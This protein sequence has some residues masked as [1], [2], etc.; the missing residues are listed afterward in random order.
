M[1]YFK[2]DGAC[3]F[4]GPSG[5]D[6][7]ETVKHDLPRLI[8]SQSAADPQHAI[9]MVRALLA[10]HGIGHREIKTSITPALTMPDGRSLPA[11]LTIFGNGFQ[12]SW[13]SLA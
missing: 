13:K 2:L 7:L 3:F 8:P 11:R 4:Y 12:F 1:S 10:Q 6:I 5:Y 9:N